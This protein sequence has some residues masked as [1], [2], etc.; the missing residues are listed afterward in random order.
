MNPLRLRARQFR[1]WGDVDLELPAGVCAI[2]GANGAGKSSLLTMIEI[3]LFG[4][5]SRSLAPYLT[6]GAADTEMMVELELEHRG[7]VYRVRR[8]YSARGRGQAK[9]DLERRE[10]HEVYAPLTRESA[11]ETQALIE[12]TLGLSRSTFRASAFL[13]QGDG[14]CFAEAAPS[15]RKEILADILGL[16]EWDTRRDRVRADRR[17]VEDET[18]RLTARIETAETEVAAAGDAGGERDIAQALLD[19]TRG[20]IQSLEQALADAERQLGDAQRAR[21]QIAQ[22][23]QRV[24]QHAD[25]VARHD[26]RL[27]RLTDEDAAIQEEIAGREALTNLAARVPEL[28]ARLAELEAQAAGHAEY[29]RERAR[30]ERAVADAR[31][32]REQA[33]H[34][35]DRLAERARDF[36]AQA[37]EKEAGG[38][39]TCQTCGQHVRGESLA[40][41]VAELRRQAE[42][43]E[44]EAVDH[45]W[46]AALADKTIAKGEAL[47]GQPAPPAPEPA[48]P[49]RDELAR[50][51][52]AQVALAALDARAHRL[53]QI[54]LEIEEA[55]LAAGLAR[56]AQADAQAALD[57]L[58]A[59]ATG[60]Q[61]DELEAETQR[62][63]SQLAAARTAADGHARTVARCD[64]RLDRLTRLHA[65]LTEDRAE[66]A[67]HAHRLEILRQLDRAFSRDG[68][69]ALILENAAVPQIEAEA[70]RILTELGTPYQVELRTQRALKGSDGVKDVLDIVVTDAGAERDYATYSGGERTRLNLA[71]RIAL[72]RLLAH[73][74]GADVRM[75]ALDEPDALDEEG[76]A[77]LVTVL[78]SLTGDFDTVL[79]VSHHPSLIDAVDQVI[80]IER[81]ADGLSRVAGTREEVAA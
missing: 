30:V 6:V 59:H 32:S 12:Q 37:A 70:C 57:E 15:R 31:A 20:Q 76:M 22:A 47:L 42:T 56:M 7:D 36:D 68:I 5:E 64:E 60:P 39:S 8:S 34:L 10:G 4:A 73:R 21:E 24:R 79:L 51:R 48:D 13:A 52:E 50:G 80:T 1:S 33:H 62:L 3:A 17:Q 45:R 29:A 27:G 41:A 26:T 28:E 38:A 74:R 53:D 19:H 65:Q 77:R 69:P 49:V 40:R 54:G 11:A 23:V 35:A 61:E 67:R 66:H 63:R 81:D 78:H 25:E 58:T 44:A 43:A 72:A 9:V 46:I 55:T 14:A 75:L 71:L 16:A 18:Q 2:V